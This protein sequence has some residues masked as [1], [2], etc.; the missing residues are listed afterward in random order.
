MVMCVCVRVCLQ[1]VVEV[2]VCILEAAGGELSACITA[3]CM[4]LADAGIALYDLAPSCSV[5]RCSPTACTNTHTHTRAHTH[6][7]CYF[8]DRPVLRRCW[9]SRKVGCVSGLSGLP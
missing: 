8:L 9:D 1:A 3:A 5:V 4:A 7:F 2:S 6:T